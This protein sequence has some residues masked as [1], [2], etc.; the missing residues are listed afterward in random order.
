M[1]SIELFINFLLENW[2]FIITILACGYLAFIKIKKWNSLSEEEKIN[3][4]LTILREQM[5]SYVAEAEQN[6]GSG[7]GTLK[8]SEVIKKVYEDYPILSNVIE[9]DQLILV[10]D[11]YIDESLVELRKL[12][13]D[14][15]EFKKLI[16]GL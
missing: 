10:L 1:K 3:T 16:L 15:K 8:R 7:T 11:K 6:F 14:N 5:L 2:T 4:S 9:Q 13:E 12:L